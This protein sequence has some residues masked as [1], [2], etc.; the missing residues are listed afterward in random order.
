M[1]KA[2]TH[3]ELSKLLSSCELRFG[4]KGSN[5]VLTVENA[6]GFSRRMPLSAEE[7]QFMNATL[8]KVSKAVVNE[9]NAALLEHA[10]TCTD[11]AFPEG[12]MH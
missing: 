3:F 1:R 11:A 7:E 12:R 4:F 8:F 10:T 5:L 2:M 6:A 9:V